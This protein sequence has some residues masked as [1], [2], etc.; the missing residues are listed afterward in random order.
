MTPVFAEFEQTDAQKI[1]GWTV[2]TYN[3]KDT[4]RFT[5]CMVDTI[6]SAQTYEQSKRMRT[7]ALGFAISVAEVDG[8]EWMQIMLMGYQ[9]NLVVGNKYKVEF[10]FDDN[11]LSSINITATD[12]DVLKEPFPPNG[13]WYKRMME[14]N[15]L[16][17][18]IDDQSIGTFSMEKSGKALTEL[19]NCY[20]RNSRPTFGPGT[21]T[22]EE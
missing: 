17:I 7:K 3:D 5:H 9:W 15:V 18:I 10:V 13:E 4:G 1:G 2:G 12:K 8:K 21:S 19:L 11:L 16:E 6:F 20:E 22:G 14:A